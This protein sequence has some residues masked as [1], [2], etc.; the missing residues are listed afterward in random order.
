MKGFL[1]VIVTRPNAIAKLNF[2]DSINELC[3]ARP[4]GESV[5][6]TEPGRRK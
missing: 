5:D 2:P 6:T 3:A 1:G 4:A